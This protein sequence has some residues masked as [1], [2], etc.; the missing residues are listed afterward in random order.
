MTIFFLLFSFISFV[1]RY[2]YY[3]RNNIVSVQRKTSIYKL[4]A[5]NSKKEEKIAW[6]ALA[7]TQPTNIIMRVH[8]KPYQTIYT[9]MRAK[10]ICF[11]TG[12]HQHSDTSHFVRPEKLNWNPYS[13]S[14]QPATCIIRK[15]P[16]KKQTKATST[17]ARPQPLSTHPPLR[18]SR[19]YLS[20]IPLFRYSQTNQATHQHH[21]IHQSAPIQPNRI[22]TPTIAI[23][24]VKIV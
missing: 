6:N 21:L 3:N 12:K 24:L 8:I 23:C 5:M 17:Q 13:K 22:C 20:P 19:L 1:S 16:N 14:S 10:H 9:Y 18:S 2:K 4:S 11:R 7:K 15:K